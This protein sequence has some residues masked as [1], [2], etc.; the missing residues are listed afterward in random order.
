MRDPSWM[1]LSEEIR[2]KD[3]H[4]AAGHPVARTG[5]GVAST[6]EAAPVDERPYEGA[7][8]EYRAR[9]RGFWIGTGGGW[10]TLAV[11]AWLL[12][13]TRAEPVLAVLFPIWGLAWFAGTIYSV[14][15]LVV[16]ACPRCG[17]TFF[18][19]LVSPLFQWKCRSCGLRKFAPND[20]PSTFRKVP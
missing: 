17:N 15:K 5:A 2:A 11:L 3:G 8:A 1:K 20:R 7:W 16:F 4:A 12:P 18:N 13:G 19:P 9:W 6:I 14:L 10:L